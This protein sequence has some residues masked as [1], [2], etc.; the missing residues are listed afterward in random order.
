MKKFIYI[1]LSLIIIFSCI[2]IYKINT[3]PEY[4]SKLYA[5]IYSEY[6]SIM[7]EP[8]LNIITNNTTITNNTPNKVYI[9]Q[10]TNSTYKVIATIE[11]PKLNISYPI[12]NEYN[13]EY[14]KIAP[15]KLLGPQPNQVGNFVITRS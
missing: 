2:L 3:T 8:E 6:N 1:C 13:E 15:T 9:T 5:E 7:C 11:I 12:I 10:T 14:L 4:D